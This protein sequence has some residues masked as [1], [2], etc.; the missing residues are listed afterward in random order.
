MAGGAPTGP[1]RPR[2]RLDG[3]GKAREDARIETIR[4]G[5]VAEGLRK[6]PDLT[7]IDHR[8]RQGCDQQFG[9]Q[10]AFE[11]TR[12][13]QHDQTRLLGLQGLDQA[14]DAVRIMRDRE[15]LLGKRNVHIQ[16][17][18]RDVDANPTYLGIHG[19]ASPYPALQNRALRPGNCS[20]C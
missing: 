18:L 11:P 3:L 2:R 10:G 20:G 8:H 12:R 5:Q 6:V 7:W 9:D 19:H 13:L 4:L 15:R 14:S 1:P 17:R 16:R